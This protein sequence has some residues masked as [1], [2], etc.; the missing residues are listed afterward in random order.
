[1][2]Q[3]ELHG[4]RGRTEKDAEDRRSGGP[5]ETIGE[6][7]LPRITGSTPC[8]VHGSLHQTQNALTVRE[9]ARDAPP[10]SR[11]GKDSVRSQGASLSGK[12]ASTGRMLA[13]TMSAIPSAAAAPTAWFAAARLAA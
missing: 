13:P 8:E 1:M 10:Q 12:G 11:A 7:R 6:F 5:L 2:Q 9:T 4:G 3:P